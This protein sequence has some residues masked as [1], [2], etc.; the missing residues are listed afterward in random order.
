V[1]GRRNRFLFKAVRRAR[2]AFASSLR[3]STPFE[4]SLAC[5]EAARRGSAFAARALRIFALRRVTSRELQGCRALIA[6]LKQ[7]ITVS[8]RVWGSPGR[9]VILASSWRAAS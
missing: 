2:R 9:L 4:L 1:L 5:F 6:Q 7:A 3:R 8:L